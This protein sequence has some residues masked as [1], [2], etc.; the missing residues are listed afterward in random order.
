MDPDTYLKLTDEI[1]AADTHAT[2]ERLREQVGQTEMHWLERQALERVLRSRADTLRLLDAEGA[3][4]RPGTD[5][6]GDL[7]GSPP[8]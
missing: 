3:P 8:A 6:L 1:A 5:R 2:L 4:P 7:D